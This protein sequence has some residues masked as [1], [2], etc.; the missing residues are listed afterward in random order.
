MLSA[1]HGTPR[2]NLLT[3]PPAFCAPSNESRDGHLIPSRLVAFTLLQE[4]ICRYK[5]MY[6]E[7]ANIL[8]DFIWL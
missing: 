2:S 5:Q 3:H 6:K 8:K 7:P 1:S 4:T